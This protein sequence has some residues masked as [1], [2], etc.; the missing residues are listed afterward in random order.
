MDEITLLASSLPDAP[1]PSPEVVARAR[2]RLSAAETTR[3]V[4]RR[5]RLRLRPWTWTVATAVATAAVILAVTAGVGAGG[6]PGDGPATAVSAPTGPQALL[7]I[8]ARAEALPAETPGAY[9]RRRTVNGSLTRWG[10]GAGRYMM[11]STS[12]LDS[13]TPRDPRDPGFTRIDKLADRPATPE[14]AA[15]WRER[16]APG[17]RGGAPSPDG[18]IAECAGEADC[19]PKRVRC[20]YSWEVDPKG[21]LYDRRMGELTFADLE[22]LPRDADAL[23]ERFKAIPRPDGPS[24]EEDWFFSAV[25]LL[26]LPS[27]PGLRAAALRILAGLPGT[28][29]V[30]E[31]TDPLGRPGVAVRINAEGAG[32]SEIGDATVPTDYQVVLD[33]VTG[34]MIG[35]RSTVVRDTEGV[36]AGT[37]IGYAAYTEQGWTGERPERPQGCKEGP[38]G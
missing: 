30:G 24:R 22:A 14:D 26:N 36:S 25:S 11:L 38:V 16:G 27:P 37:V 28:R 20:T 19:A 8:A 23:L 29:M 5:V 32:E 4:R 6:G 15:T 12:E 34:E 7:D 13:W 18:P 10:D 1:P 35:D 3:P 33:P 21:I 31:I 17:R 9:W 2:A